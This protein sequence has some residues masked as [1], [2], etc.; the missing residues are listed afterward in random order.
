MRFRMLSE[1]CDYVQLMHRFVFYAGTD[2]DVWQFRTLGTRSQW[3][4]LW[5]F[6]CLCGFFMLLLF[7]FQIANKA[8][9]SSNAQTRRMMAHAPPFFLGK[10][11]EEQWCLLLPMEWVSLPLSPTLCK[12]KNRSWA[13]R[14]WDQQRGCSSLGKGS[15]CCFLLWCSSRCW[16]ALTILR[17][18]LVGHRQLIHLKMS[19]LPC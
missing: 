11:E 7:V 15:V 5:F 10:S 6:V 12:G 16:E 9:A 3:E 8:S 14:H 17:D 2:I 1:G 19:L 13:P 4:P 18:S